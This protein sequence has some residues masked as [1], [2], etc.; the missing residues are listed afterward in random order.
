MC[1]FM[2]SVKPLVRRNAKLWENKDPVRGRSNLRRHRPSA[3]TSHTSRARRCPSGGGSCEV[4]HEQNKGPKGGCLQLNPHNCAWP[5]GTETK[6]A[7]AAAEPRVGQAGPGGHGAAPG[8]AQHGGSGHTATH[9]RKKRI[10]LHA[11]QSGLRHHFAN[12]KT[13]MTRI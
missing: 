5:P 11:G 13:N 8:T 6:P 1:E 10:K 3:V 4:T 12:F 7:G 2:C 9:L